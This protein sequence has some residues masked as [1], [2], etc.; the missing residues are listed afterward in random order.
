MMFGL[1]GSKEVYVGL[2]IGNYY[3]KVVCA[4]AVWQ[5]IKNLKSAKV[6]LCT[7]IAVQNIGDRELLTNELSN[8]FSSYKTQKKTVKVI[9]CM[10]SPNVIVRSIEVPKK[11]N[12]DK[13]GADIARNYVPYKIEEAKYELIQISDEIPEAPDKKEVLLISFL[14]ED[15]VVLNDIISN[16]GLEKV[17]IEF[18]ELGVWRLLEG[19]NYQNFKNTNSIVID[20]G[21]ISTK[22]MV[23]YN[24]KLKQL[25]NLRIAGEEIK[26]R[27]VE[28][29]GSMEFSDDGWKFVTF[30]DQKYSPILIKAFEP[31]V[32]ELKRTIAAYK[33]RM[34]FPNIYTIGGISYISGLNE[35]IQK[36]VSI[37]VNYIELDK[38]SNLIKIDKKIEGDFKREFNIY[39]NAFGLALGHGQQ[40]FVS[41]R[42]I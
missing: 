37:P 42:I 18:D 16:A 28:K 4:D 8:L 31:L 36:E 7:K 20:F 6:D 15:V 12:I 32:K 9:A 5:D 2:D 25:R 23:F 3:M 13:E 11:V 21:Y 33:G 35:Y 27:I 14:L 10:S 40:K 19:A 34:D 29:V 22:I 38:M 30:D 39:V 26:K 1:F 24:G 17:A 41:K